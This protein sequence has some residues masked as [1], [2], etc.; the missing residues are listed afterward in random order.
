MKNI[1]VVG[2]GTAGWLTALVVN[3]FHKDSS[4]TLIE[5]TKFGILGAGEGSVSNFGAILKLLNINKVDFFNKTK[6][7]IKDG[8]NFVNWRGDGKSVKHL[9]SGKNN[10]INV[11]NGFHFDARLVASYFRDLSIERGVVHIDSII[12]NCTKDKSNIISLTLDNDDIINTDFIFDCSGFKR[13]IIGKFYNEEWV[14]YNEYL[15]VNS[16]VAYFLPQNNKLS[17]KNNTQTNMISMKCGWMWQAP[18]QHRWGCGYV[19]NDK[20]ISNEEAKKEIEEYVGQEIDVVKTFKYE[21]GYF[22]R[23][24]V[25]NSI[26]IGLSSTFLEPLESTSLMSSIMQL[27]RL[28]DINFNES[29][30]DK[31]NV[32]CEEVSLQNMIFVRYHYMCG[33]DDTQFWKDYKKIN[34][35]EPL[36]KLVNKDGSLKIK[37][38]LDIYNLLE[39][40]ECDISQLTFLYN[41]YFTIHKTNSIKFEHNII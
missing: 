30:R 26:A 31:F 40:K 3:K 13:L 16:A 37:N 38:N 9:L 20:Y 7:T 25:G 28:I 22:K 24:W 33:R 32:F 12:K 41:N 27:K 34:I 21:P 39:L 23:S 35:P 11:N 1:V 2:G 6:S 18:L 19:F 10:H 29:H 36:S 14:S 4:V 8:L 5:S 15:K 17:I